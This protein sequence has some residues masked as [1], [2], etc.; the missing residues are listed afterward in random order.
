MSKFEKGNKKGK[1]RPKGA[2]NKRT[3]T[4]EAFTD[5][6][7]NGGLERFKR[8]MNSLKGKQF[9]DTFLSILEFHKPKQ[10]RTVVTGEDGEPLVPREI[11]IEIVK[12]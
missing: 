7:L 1:G 3:E 10:A 11:K 8:E 6:C 12:K 5:Y 9:T 4:W 2:A